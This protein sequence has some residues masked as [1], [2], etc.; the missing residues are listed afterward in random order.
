MAT[1]STKNEKE[2]KIQADFQ[3]NKGKVRFGCV[4]FIIFVIIL[5]LS[6]SKTVSDTE[7]SNFT[8]IP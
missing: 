2:T 5:C 7:K 6:C 1:K 4:S 3:K 8:T